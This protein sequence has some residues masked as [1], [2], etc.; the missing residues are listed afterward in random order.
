MLNLKDKKQVK[1]VTLAI[2]AFFVLGFVGLAAT[3]SGRIYAAAAANTSNVGV[4]NYQLLLQS[5]PDIPKAQAAMKTEAE[6]AQK[7]FDAKS[8]TMNDKEKQD[9]YMQ[10]QQRLSNKQQELMGPIHDSITAAIKAVADAKGI[11][12]VLDKS[13]VVYGGQDITDDVMKKITGK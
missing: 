1:I 3:Q 4:V 5:H 9:Y 2:V 10:L 13:N 6:S 12:V 11:T 8:A 7:D